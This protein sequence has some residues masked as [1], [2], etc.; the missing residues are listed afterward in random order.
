MGKEREIM[1]WH[2]ISA[3]DIGSSGG[4]LICAELRNVDRGAPYKSYVEAEARARHIFDSKS[5]SDLTKALKRRMRVAIVSVWSD[6]RIDIHQLRKFH[7]GEPTLSVCRKRTLRNIKIAE[8][9]DRHDA[10]FTG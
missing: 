4:P 2:V 1:G 6:G 3:I 5:L 10:Q 7:T 8:G 9:R